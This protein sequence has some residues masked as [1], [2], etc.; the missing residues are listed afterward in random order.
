M[1]RSPKPGALGEVRS[2]LRKLLALKADFTA[3]RPE[4]G[5]ADL[6][7]RAPGVALAV[8]WKPVGD[9]AN[10]GS[11]IRQLGRL[12]GH[13]G[14]RGKPMISV[15]AVPF[16]GE[17]GRGL[18][19][20]AGV[21]WIDLSGNAWIDAPGRQIHILGNRNRFASRGRPA[22][23]FAPKSS[24]VVRVLLMEPER[25][26]TQAELAAASGV[27]RG[28]VS[29]LV[30]RLE[31]MD[32]VDRVDSK[33]VRI[34]DPLVALDAWREAYDF[35]Q[36]RITQGIM[37]GRSSE[38]VMRRLVEALESRGSE[39]A[40]TGLAGAWLLNHHAMFRI[41]TVLLRD[42][43]EPA[44]LADLRFQ[45]G[46]RGVNVWLAV[47]DDDGPLMGRRKDSGAYCAHPLQVYLDLKAH[48]ERAP[49]AAAELRRHLFPS[50]ARG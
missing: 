14:H 8:E 5:L 43:V 20:E 25:A 45:E 7:L 23:V 40:L 15:V 19:A 12:R 21:S 1:P 50:Q 18:C 49:E 11:A 34:K 47:P 10:V 44:L 16:M 32:L 17:T 42:P 3:E 28:R 31:A 41:V 24:R 27:D 46:P 36:H 13:R 35:G 6:V 48:P 9:A 38:E 29:R 30:R 2:E 39:Y 37:G 22:N 26:F 33:A 4:P